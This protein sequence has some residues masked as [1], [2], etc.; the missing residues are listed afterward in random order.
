[1]AKII[2]FYRF[3]TNSFWSIKIAFKYNLFCLLD[4]VNLMD[5]IVIKIRPSRKIF[6]SKNVKLKY[7]FSLEIPSYKEMLTSRIEQRVFLSFGSIIN[8]PI[9]TT[10][11]LLLLLNVMKW[12]SLHMK[13]NIFLADAFCLFKPNA[14]IL[15]SHV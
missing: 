2:H 15:F 11:M 6:H 7:R 10:S 14:R 5:Y 13:G 4:I 12:C 8:P 1:M 9:K 3:K